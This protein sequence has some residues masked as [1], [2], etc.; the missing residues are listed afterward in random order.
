LVKYRA[1]ETG[2]KP[3]YVLRP[4][5]RCQLR[6][7][8]LCLLHWLVLL[9][10]LHRLLLLLLLFPAR[11][12]CQLYLRLELFAD[13]LHLLLYLLPHGLP[14]VLVELRHGGLEGLRK[15]PL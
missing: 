5:R 11:L 2:L 6:R 4:L 8:P 13:W 9:C 12:T 1:E 10:L 7:L 3:L 15:V 14:E